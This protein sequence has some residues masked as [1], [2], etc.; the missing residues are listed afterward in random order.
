MGIAIVM[1]EHTGGPWLS[2]GVPFLPVEEA[3]AN[4]TEPDYKTPL[5]TEQRTTFLRNIRGSNAGD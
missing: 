2:R 1:S 3:L 5:T 4:L